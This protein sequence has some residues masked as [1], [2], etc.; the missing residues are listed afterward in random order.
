MLKWVICRAGL[1]CHFTGTVL[2]DV[3]YYFGV[4]KIRSVY[5][6]DP[7]IVLN[8]IIL[9]FIGYFKICI[10]TASMN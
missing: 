1:Q 7:L 8:N 5:Y 2:P 3:R 4:N 6:V 10:K 9:L